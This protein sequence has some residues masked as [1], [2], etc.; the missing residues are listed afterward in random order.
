MRL[1]ETLKDEV[2]TVQD[3]QHLVLENLVKVTKFIEKLDEKATILE[4]D[5]EDEDISI[6]SKQKNPAARANRQSVK[7]D[8]EIIKEEENE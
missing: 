8:H 3:D 2:G 5:D 1:V 7:G 6:Y 4:E